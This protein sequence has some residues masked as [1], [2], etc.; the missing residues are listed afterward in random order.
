MIK[1]NKFEKQNL[2]AG[3]ASGRL[4]KTAMFETIVGMQMGGNT[5]NN[6][7][8]L[9]NQ[10]IF[11]SNPENRKLIAQNYTYQHSYIRGAGSGYSSTINMA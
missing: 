4:T 11:Y 1:L 5:I 9:L 10:V 7:L 2:V 6:Y 8:N 3:A